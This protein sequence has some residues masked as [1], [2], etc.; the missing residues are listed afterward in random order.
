MNIAVTFFLAMITAKILP[1]ESNRIPFIYNIFP[2][3][4]FESAYISSFYDIFSNSKFFSSPISMVNVFWT[5]RLFPRYF[6]FRSD[7]L[8]LTHCKSNLCTCFFD[9]QIFYLYFNYIYFNIMSIRTVKFNIP[10]I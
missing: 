6:R 9:K 1:P 7:Y 8:H 5:H 2:T 3:F 4:T 10:S